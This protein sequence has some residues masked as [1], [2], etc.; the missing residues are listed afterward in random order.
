MAY[1]VDVAGGDEGG[2]RGEVVIHEAP[3]VAL[4]GYVRHPV[5]LDLMGLP[6]PLL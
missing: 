3:P 4:H 5:A 2:E 1:A 6:A